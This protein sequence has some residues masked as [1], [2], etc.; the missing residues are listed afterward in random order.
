[1]RANPPP[2][3]PGPMHP[4]PRAHAPTS[5]STFDHL[6]TLPRAPPEPSFKC[7]STQPSACHALLLPP[8]HTTCHLPTP[9]ATCPPPPTPYL[10]PLTLLTVGPH[11]HALLR[12]LLQCLVW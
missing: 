11:P 3:S 5:P 6:A 8:A 2:L 7:A 1:C 9:P 10:P 12:E 4:L